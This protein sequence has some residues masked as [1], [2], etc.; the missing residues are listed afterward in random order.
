V[1][2]LREVDF[3]FEPQAEGGGLHL[4]APD[5]PGLHAQRDSLD[6]AAAMSASSTPTANWLWPLRCT[7]S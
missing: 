7:A 1:E 2:P 5:L 3:V 6:E 4:Y